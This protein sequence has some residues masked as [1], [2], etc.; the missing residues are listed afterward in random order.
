[1]QVL[2]LD[3]TTRSPWGRQAPHA[4]FSPQGI[5]PA[6]VVLQASRTDN[7]RAPA[8][9]A[10]FAFLYVSNL[11]LVTQYAGAAHNTATA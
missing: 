8:V 7:L 5:Y 6:A 4:P 3:D 9:A 1:V 10:L 2:G 11:A